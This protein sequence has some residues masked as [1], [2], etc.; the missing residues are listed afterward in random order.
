MSSAEA[1]LWALDTHTGPDALSEIRQ[2]LAGIW[3]AHPEVPESVRTE[4]AIATGEI[5]ANIIEHAAH[6]RSV[7]IRMEVVVLADE[8]QVRF[9][10]DGLELGLDLD[11]VC[12]PEATAERGRGLAVARAVLRQLSYQRGPDGNRWTLLSERFSG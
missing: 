9:I 12:L 2:T 4:I 1:R 11:T 8:V 6:D 3:R 5:A 7:R 10:D